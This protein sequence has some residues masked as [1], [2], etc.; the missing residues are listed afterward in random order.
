MKINEIENIKTIE[1]NDEI[2][3]LFIENIS[4]IKKPLVGLISKKRTGQQTQ[5]S[6]IGI[7]RGDITINSTDT[8]RI[9][10]AI[11]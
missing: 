5:I 3:R 4:S 1:K 9:N 8:K 2:T 11:L 10:E 6:N 7:E